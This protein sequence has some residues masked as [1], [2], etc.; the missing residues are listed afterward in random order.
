MSRWLRGDLRRMNIL[1]H[2]ACP[3][4]WQSSHRYTDTDHALGLESP[5]ESVCLGQP[6]NSEKSRTAIAKKIKM[7]RRFAVPSLNTMWTALRV[8][9]GMLPHWLLSLS[10]VFACPRVFSHLIPTC[11][12][13]SPGARGE[14]G[15]TQVC[16]HRCHFRSIY[17]FVWERSTSALFKEAV[18]YF[19]H[20]GAC[21]GW[22]PAAGKLQKK[23]TP[24]AGQECDFLLSYENCFLGYKQNSSVC[25]LSAQPR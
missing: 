23:H 1:A 16:L 6:I 9:T 18:T 11:P 14:Q 21:Q 15:Q 20:Q 8:G 12:C 4:N 25:W 3:G 22:T 2:L 5:I 7:W 19:V 24:K 17:I 13:R 10:P